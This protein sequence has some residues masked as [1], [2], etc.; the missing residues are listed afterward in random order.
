MRARN[1]QRPVSVPPEAVESTEV[2]LIGSVFR[3]TMQKL[4][5]LGGDPS[6]DTESRVH[7]S[8]SEYS[9]SFV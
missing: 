5:K 7:S 2:D 4:L 9:L 1:V 6:V 3:S 8:Q